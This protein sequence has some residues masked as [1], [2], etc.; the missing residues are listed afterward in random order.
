MS[1]KF[2]GKI[3]ENFSQ[4]LSHSFLSDHQLLKYYCHLERCV[5]WLTRNRYL[6]MET[7][8]FN[9]K[10]LFLDLPYYE[11]FCLFSSQSSQEVQFL[12]VRDFEHFL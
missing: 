10:M 2:Y 3:I 4:N 5:K 9:T 8:N 6:I 7:L 12:Y 11:G 1:L